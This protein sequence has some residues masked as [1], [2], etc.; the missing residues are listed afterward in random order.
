MCIEHA[1]VRNAR[2]ALLFTSHSGSCGDV[3]SGRRYR[4]L[5]RFPFGRSQVRVDR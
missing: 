1:Y 2:R 3:N 5:W 4:S